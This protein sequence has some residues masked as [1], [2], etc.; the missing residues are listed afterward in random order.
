MLSV[1]RLLQL[2]NHLFKKAK[3]D[4]FKKFILS[5]ISQ[6]QFFGQENN[7][8]RKVLQ[9]GR[10]NLAL[11]PKFN[12]KFQGVTFET[13]FC[14]STSIVFNIEIAQCLNNSNSTC[15]S[16]RRSVRSNRCWSVTLRF[17]EIGVQAVVDK[18][19]KKN[20]SLLEL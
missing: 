13:F 1:W 11:L 15:I 9:Q 8:V 3:D 7:G 16:R 17:F 14:L 12:L 2:K 20:C 6:I 10:A 4:L 5:V 18:K 19:L